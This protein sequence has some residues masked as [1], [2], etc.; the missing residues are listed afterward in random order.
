MKSK[1]WYR[2]NSA[3]ILAMT[4]YEPVDLAVE[5]DRE[6]P[7]VI[8]ILL[9][10]TAKACA[11]A[12]RQR[13]DGSLKASPLTMA[14][15]EHGTFAMVHYTNRQI[16]LRNFSTRQQYSVVMP[17]KLAECLEAFQ[18]GVP[19]LEDHEFELILVSDE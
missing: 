18:R 17:S 4:S 12:A 6:C 7:H 15:L 3:N 8:S 11:D 2:G 19:D 16:T 5:L 13:K 9:R 14:L 10:V 1:Q